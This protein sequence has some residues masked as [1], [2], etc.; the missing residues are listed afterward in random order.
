MVNAKQILFQWMHLCE[1]IPCLF[2]VIMF[3]LDCFLPQT[4]RFNYIYPNTECAVRNTIIGFSK[5]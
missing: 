4:G 3:Q 2:K 1:K 5:E